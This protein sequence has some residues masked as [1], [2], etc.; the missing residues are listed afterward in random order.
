MSELTLDGVSKAYG[1]TFAVQDFSLAI[2]HGELLALLG[3]SGCGKTTTL[4]MI[5]GFVLPS[6]GEIRIGGSDVTAEP[7]YRRSTGMAF[8]GYALL[9]HMSVAQNVAFGLGIRCRA[10]PHRATMAD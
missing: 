5:A 2:A 9:P 1:G 3:P 4:R 10:R 6:A 8:Q 7:P